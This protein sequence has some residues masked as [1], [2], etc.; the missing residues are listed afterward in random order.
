MSVEAI[1][2]WRDVLIDVDH[3]SGLPD[4]HEEYLPVACAKLVREHLSVLANRMPK[5]GS[6][7]SEDG[8]LWLEQH[9][10]ERFVLCRVMLQGRRA[11]IRISRF[12]GSKRDGVTEVLR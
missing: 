5:P 12:N 10:G 4:H 9:D 11:V 6:W 2:N 3:W 7:S 8:E 1:G